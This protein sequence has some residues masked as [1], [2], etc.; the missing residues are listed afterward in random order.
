MH[1]YAGATQNRKKGLTT[2]QFFEASGVSNISEDDQ[3]EDS[4]TR[5]IEERKLTM[6]RLENHKKKCRRSRHRG[7]QQASQMYEHRMTK[8]K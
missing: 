7:H 4:K 8:W 3:F 1:A 6:E 5:F 2:A